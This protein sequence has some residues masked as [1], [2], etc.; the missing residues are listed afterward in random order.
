MPTPPLAPRTVGSLDPKTKDQQ[1][2]RAELRECL[3][4]I[5]RDIDFLRAYLDSEELLTELIQIV[6]QIEQDLSSVN[7]QT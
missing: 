3:N 6:R 7:G 1:A 4:S 5:N 2:L